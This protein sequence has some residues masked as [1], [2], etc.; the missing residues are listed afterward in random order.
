MAI[1]GAGNTGDAK[2][3]AE[4]AKANAARAAASKAIASKAPAPKVAPKPAAPKPAA[5]KPA[6]PKSKPI[7]GVT[8]QSQITQ[9]DIKNRPNTNLGIGPNGGRLTD[10]SPAALGMVSGIPSMAEGASLS[11]P[12]VS[13]AN[14]PAIPAAN[15]DPAY[16]Q[17]SAGL[18]NALANFMAAQKLRQ[19]QYN[20]QF[21][22]QLRNMGWSDSLGGFDPRGVGS[23]GQ[24]FQDNAGD[25]AGRGA[26]FS[27]PYSTS[28]GN[29]NSL[30]NQQKTGMETA[31]QR[32]SDTLANET[33]TQQQTINMQKQQALLDA[34][35][36]IAQNYSVDL[37]TVLAK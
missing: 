13:V 3:T 21:G 18:D 19:D 24:S 32:Y 15:L 23:Y 29:M 12:S 28:V 37:G 14:G 9:N 8:S 27:G 1:L 5:P 2:A 26:Y 17:Q 7:S 10:T 20:Q 35:Q 36:R 6:A 34:A 31:K 30:Y 25:F 33:A 11:G 4:A 22:E 16:Q